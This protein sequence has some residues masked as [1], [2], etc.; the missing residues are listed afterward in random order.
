MLG[1]NTLCDTPDTLIHRLEVYMREARD[2]DDIRLH[3][4]NHALVIEYQDNITGY[5]KY[6]T[7]SEVRTFGN[8]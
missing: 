4:A 7:L 6:D 3:M 1:L 8:T 2:P 5:K